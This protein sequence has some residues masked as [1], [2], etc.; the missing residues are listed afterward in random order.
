MNPVTLPVVRWSAR[1]RLIAAVFVVASVAFGLWAHSSPRRTLTAELMAAGIFAASLFALAWASLFRITAEEEGLWVRSLRGGRRV[2]WEEI[3]RVELIAQ[4]QENGAIV[5]VATTDPAAAYHVVLML[6]GGDRIN[7][8][9]AMDGIDG[10]LAALGQKGALVLDDSILR[11]AVASD[12][13]AVARGV[14][15][16]GRGAKM[17]KVALGAVLLTF[18]VSLGL[19]STRAFA[20]TGNLFVDMGAVAALLLGAFAGAVALARALRARRF[21][22]PSR[23]GEPGAGDLVM[24]YAAA[25]GGPLLLIWFVPRVVAGADEGRHIDVI[26]V[27]MG[28][29]LASVP[30]RAF[31]NHAFRS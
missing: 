21:G 9:R 1:A 11:A 25:L 14:A 16:V 28:L 13:Y 12:A 19:A 26:L 10:L 6:R 15:A 2:R 31:Y 24:I 4:W 27:L 22:S 7:L 29:L 8:N 23:E 3:E 20:L 18:I 17:A 30:L 5:R